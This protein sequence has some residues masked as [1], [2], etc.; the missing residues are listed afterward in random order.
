M[1]TCLTRSASAEPGRTEEMAPPTTSAS[2]A[3]T[4]WARAGSPAARSS[5]TRSSMLRTKVTPAALRTCR[6]TG[7]S[8]YGTLRSPAS[9]A[10]STSSSDQLRPSAVRATS[11]ASGRS[12]R[13]ATVG[14]TS[15]RSTSREPRTATTQGPAHPGSKRRPTRVAVSVSWGRTRSA[16][17]VRS[18]VR[19]FLEE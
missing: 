8:R 3:R 14:S 4:S 17:A 12:S 15:V 7:A 5:M 19:A 1:S 16:W 9:V 11:T 13:S 2:F 18:M 10:V 6:S